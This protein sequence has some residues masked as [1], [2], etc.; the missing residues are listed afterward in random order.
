MKIVSSEIIS[1]SQISLFLA[2]N[3]YFS[4]RIFP[5]TYFGIAELRKKY[6]LGHDAYIE[7]Y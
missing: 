2:F 5:G 1:W 4:R 6:Y 3:Q 7:I